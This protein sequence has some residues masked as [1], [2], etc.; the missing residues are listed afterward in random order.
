MPLAYFVRSSMRNSVLVYANHLYYKKRETN[1]Y[2]EWRCT[3]YFKT[4]CRC[5]CKITNDN[6]VYRNKLKHNNQETFDSE[7]KKLEV[8]ADLKEKATL[9][10]D[11][12]PWHLLS[13]EIYCFEDNFEDKDLYNFRKMIYRR[14]RKHCRCPP[15]LKIDMLKELQSLTGMEE[16]DEL[17]RVVKDEIVL[18]A[19]KKDLHLLDRDNLQV[20][21]DG[22]FKY[23]PRHFKQM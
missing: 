13:A 9:Y 18:I 5:A 14:R 15:K 19:R 1:N 10:P 3:K 20:F 7:L 8:S 6:K 12:K 11:E 16:E 2:S 21:C 23:S 4:K 22:T 17:I